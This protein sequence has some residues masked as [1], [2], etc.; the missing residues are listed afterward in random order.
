M[1]NDVKIRGTD[2]LVRRNLIL[3]EGLIAAPAAFC[4]DTLLHA[5]AAAFVFCCVTLL[6]VL[7]G[8]LIPRRVPF[9]LRILSY[10]LAA[11]LVY[12]PAVQAAEFLIGGTDAIALYLPLLSSGLLLTAEHDRLFTAE[13]LRVLLARL[14]CMLGGVCGVLLLLGLLRELL[15]AGKILGAQLLTS[16]PLPVLLTPA[17]GLILL[18]VLCCTANT[19]QRGAG[20]EE[21]ADDSH[22]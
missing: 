22:D 8:A 21:A 12:I 19:A 18:A 2:Y 14:A 1:Q 11:A 5:L 10:S 15:G 20:E 17:C 13:K 4:T 9:V 3:S 7:L 16:P 6:T